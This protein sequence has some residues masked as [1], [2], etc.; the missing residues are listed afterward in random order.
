MGYHCLPQLFTLVHPFTLSDRPCFTEIYEALVA[1]RHAESG[2][3][4]EIQVSGACLKPHTCVDEPAR[5]RSVGL[6]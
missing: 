4:S 3:A 2:R 6:V 1:I 5:S